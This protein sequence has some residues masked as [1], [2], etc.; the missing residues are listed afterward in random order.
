[1]KTNILNIIGVLL[2]A[3]GF[4]ACNEDNSGSM[5]VNG[6]CRRC[7]PPSTPRTTWW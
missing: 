1:M 2:I 5:D 4:V 3:C 6:D 7:L